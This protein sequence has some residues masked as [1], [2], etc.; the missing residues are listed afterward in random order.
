MDNSST[1][2]ENN[3]ITRLLTIYRELLDI[4]EDNLKRLREENDRLRLELDRV[5]GLLKMSKQL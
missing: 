4:Q 3:K 5:Y 1:S 2:E